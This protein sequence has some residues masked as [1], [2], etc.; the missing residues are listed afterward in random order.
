MKSININFKNTILVTIGSFVC[1]LLTFLVYYFLFKS[2]ELFF[3]RDNN[4]NFVSS[5][6]LGYGTTLLIS[7][8]LI[9]FSRFKEWI[10]ASLLTSAFSAF[11]ITMGIQFYNNVI[12]F[13][14]IIFVAIIFVILLLKLNKKEWF[15]YYS[16]LLALFVTTLYL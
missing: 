16:T 13:Y 11:L 5:L 3:N 15:F 8:I 9:F 6:R 7:W 2:F 14:I 4:Y 12:F 1:L 10:K